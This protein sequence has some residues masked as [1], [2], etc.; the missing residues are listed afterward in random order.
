MIEFPKDYFE[1]EIRDGFYVNGLMKKC[2][3]AQLEV[4][5]DIAKVCKRHN[6]KW[7]AD[8]GTLLGA[9]RHGGFIPWDDDTDICMFREDYIKFLSVAKRELKNIWPEYRI[10]NFHNGDY[11]EMLSRVV[12]VDTINFDEPRMK[13]FHGYP[14]SAGV[15]IFPLDYLCQDREEE[16]ERMFVTQ[17]I[18]TVAEREDLDKKTEEVEEYLTAIEEACNRKFDRTKPLKLQLYSLGEAMFS[19]YTRKESKEAALLPFWLKDESHVYPLGLYEKTV[20]IPFETVMLPA[21]ACYD[22]VLKIEYGD[23]MKIVR[24]G[25]AHDYPYH[26][27]QIKQLEEDLHEESPTY[28]R[29]TKEDLTGVERKICD[30]NPREAIKR[31]AAEFSDL[32]GQVHIEIRRMFMEEKYD[33]VLQM[34]EQ[35]QNTAIQIGTFIE[36]QEGK[37]FV[38]VRYFEEYCELV[39]KIYQGLIGNEEAEDIEFSIDGICDALDNKLSVMRN[40]IQNDMTVRKEIVILP[41]KASKWEYIE[42]VWKKALDEPNTDVIV[43]PIPYIYR[44]A[45]GESKEEIYE[46]EEFPEYV[47]ITNYLDYNF[48]KRQPDEIYIQ[49]P[50]DNDNFTITVNPYFYAKNIK[51]YTDKLVYIPCFVQEEIQVGDERAFKAMNQYVISPGVVYADKV[52]VQS[53]HMK[54]MYIK[55]LV[56]FFGEDTKEIWESKIEGKGFPYFDK[57]RAVSKNT[58]NIPTEWRRVIFKEDGSAK[59]VIMYVTG[60]SKLMEKQKKMIDKM[61]QVLAVFEDNKEDIALIWRP[62]P[63]VNAT[64]PTINPILG[65]EYNRIINEFKTAGWG[66]YDDGK[67]VS[68]DTLLNLADAYYGDPD[69]VIQKCRLM[70]MPVMIQ[71]ADVI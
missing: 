38:T 45:S 25:G 65:K 9:V 60:I 29:V 43:I 55:K 28:K 26:D 2:W 57:D 64:I 67:E 1:D 16:K 10:L 11:W 42:N 40:S 66:I 71:N 20:M 49:F 50:Y 61:Q 23:Y 37:G 58:V 47:K 7:Y 36:D 15:D 44:E 6:I 70:H 51:Q 35:C 32:L 48:E 22:E 4:L 33:V 13:K 18:F 56:D 5:S 52:V 3:A 69:K 12:N 14:F 54:E 17:M 53:E 19:L 62:D 63:L 27:A 41:Y 21:P 30:G 8:C 31:Q 46:G 68:I 24:V 39:Y 59:K 34:L